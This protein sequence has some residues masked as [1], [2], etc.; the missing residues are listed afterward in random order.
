MH[1]IQFGVL[2]QTGAESSAFD[3]SIPLMFA[4]LDVPR[5]LSRLGFMNLGTACAYL[6]QGF[7]IRCQPLVV[8]IQT[9]LD[10]QRRA[11]VSA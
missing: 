11:T 9:F 1:L 4:S 3:E 2:V 7:Q 10:H 8:N 6:D 5:S